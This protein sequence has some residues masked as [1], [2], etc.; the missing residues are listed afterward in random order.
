MTHASILAVSVDNN[1]VK[2]AFLC[3]AV[4]SVYA[5]CPLTLLWVSKVMPHPAEKRGVAIAIVNSLGNSASIYGSF[6]WPSKDAPRYVPGFST[7]MYVFPLPF[8][9]IQRTEAV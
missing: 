5:A 6:L 9:A 7:T 8:D 3:F 1:K 2:Y 4:G